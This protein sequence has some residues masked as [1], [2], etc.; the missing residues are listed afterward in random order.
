MQGRYI[1]PICISPSLLSK[2]LCQFFHPTSSLATA[3]G[4]QTL[5]N[6]EGPTRILLAWIVGSLFKIIGVKGVFYRIAG[7]QAR[8]IDDLTGTTQP[9]DKNIVLG[10]I[11]S[12]KVCDDIAKSLNIAVAIVDVNDLGRVKI[13]ASSTKKH[14]KLI[15][16]ALIDNPAGNADEQTPLVLVR[17]S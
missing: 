15:K 16:E 3:C 2:L 12:Q 7:E 17:P 11:N 6:I 13:I 9:Y 1:N 5:I 8:L 10:P 4:M 14:N